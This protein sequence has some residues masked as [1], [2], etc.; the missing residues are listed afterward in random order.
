MKNT[1]K[2][3]TEFEERKNVEIRRQE[4]LDWTEEKDFRRAELPRK[5][6]A[7]LLYG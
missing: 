1:K 5:Y 4:K 3:I 6:M 2:E 7:K